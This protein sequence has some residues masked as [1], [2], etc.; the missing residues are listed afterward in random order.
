M[1]ISEYNEMMAYMLRPAQKQNTQTADLTDDLEPGPLKDELL[2]DF[3]PS[4][5]TYEEYLRRKSVRETAAQGGVIG[6]GG[7][8]RGEE[9]P[10]NREG[11][12]LIADKD[13]IKGPLTRGAKKDQYSVR[14]RDDKTGDRFQKYFKDET[15]LNKFLETNLPEEFISAE[16]LRIIANNLKKTL[17]TLPTQTQVANEA[18]ISIQAVINRLT[19]GVDY[20][21]LTPQEVGKLG[22]E[23]G[24][25]TKTKGLVL[26]GDEEGLEKLQKKVDALNKKY[27]LADKGVS[28]NV[29]KTSSGNFGTTIQ[30]KA[31]VYR[32]ILGKTRD[33]GSL[34]ELEKELKKFSKTKLFKN[35]SKSETMKAGGIESAIKQLRNA[36]SKQDLMFDYILKSKQTPTIEELSKKFKISKDLVTKDLKRLYTNIYRR[37]AGEGAPYLPDNDKKLSNVIKKVTSMDVDLTKDSVLNLITD[38]YGDSEQGDALRSKVG[39]FYKLQKKIPKKYQ[40]FFSSQLDHI[41]PLNF[42]TQ[43]RKD[44]PAEDLIRINPL[45]GFL[46]QRAFKAQLD[47]AIGTAKRTSDT[48]EGKEALKAYSELQTFLPEVLGG[49]SKT[50][51][52]TDFG[53]KTL[54]EDKSLSKAQQTQTKKIYD[55]VLKFID[56]PKVGPLLEKIGINPELAFQGLRG[57]SQ[58]IRKNIPGFLNTFKKILREN[59]ELRVELGDEFSDIENQYA[60]LNLESDFRDFVARQEEKKKEKGIPAEAIPATAAAAYKFGK[61]ALKTAAKVLRPFGFPTVGGGFALS[62]ILS[63][64]PNYSIAGADLLLPELA[65]KTTVAS[66][67]LNP[68]GIGRY[69][70]PV[71]TTLITGDTLAKRAKQM[72]ETSDKISD[73]EAGDEQDSLL[74]EYA[75]KDYRGYDKGGI[76]SLRRYK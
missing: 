49:I 17:G 29:T 60:G 37:K 41:I 33:T 26:A 19:E 39:K 30:Y 72:M 50:G 55:S 4:Q 51:K 62:E 25:E 76:V 13:S 69:M 24:A 34:K 11:F 9:L 40:K 20:S 59:P 5:E 6:K 3:D 7:M 45:P 23:K 28:F 58:L 57:S 31:G 53:A 63:D 32:D 35:Y 44:I 8:F 46:N 43:I 10:N 75:A 71:G 42:L 52:I 18:G 48:K 36:G 12:K 2:K 73:M 1:K 64:D 22:G 38:A 68:F 15:K 66:R 70:T 61:P 65:K 54:T 74:E 16:D 27:N 47:K 21:K 67:F 56:N 14:V